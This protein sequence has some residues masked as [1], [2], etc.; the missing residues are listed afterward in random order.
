M[1][2]AVVKMSA[3]EIETQAT[4]ESDSGGQQLPVPER[5]CVEVTLIA[6]DRTC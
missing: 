2:G 5:N 1:P 3:Q 6:V 4:R